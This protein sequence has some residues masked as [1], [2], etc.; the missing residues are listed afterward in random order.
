MLDV[1][2]GLM[3]LKLFA[4]IWF[5]ALGISPI[6]L[7]AD[8]ACC[9][10]PQAACCDK[11][12][13]ACCPEGTS[14]DMKC[15]KDD[16]CDMPCCKGQSAE[17]ACCQDDPPVDNAIDVLLSLSGGVDW[18]LPSLEAPGQQMVMVWFHRPVWVGRTVL[19]GKYVIEHDTARMAR[20][21]PCTHIY[22]ADDRTKPVVAFHCTHL[23]AVRRDR[24][25]VVLQSMGDGM[26]KLVRFQFADEDSAHGYP[27]R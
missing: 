16:T 2:G 24:G 10:Q 13:K 19:M 23:K 14:C 27:S 9:D 26:K 11:A 15:C 4:L 12:A 7:A 3:R 18:S 25:E 8:E 17:M 5:F 1:I 22:A 21:E 20:G 6:V